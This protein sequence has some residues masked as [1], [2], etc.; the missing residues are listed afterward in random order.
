MK[1]ISNYLVPIALLF[2]IGFI[3]V[4]PTF[5]LPTKT[6]DRRDVSVLCETLGKAVTW[7]HGVYYVAPL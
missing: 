7:V 4:I 5:D 3:A 1:I 2:V 6:G